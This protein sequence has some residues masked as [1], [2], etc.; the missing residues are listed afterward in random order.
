MYVVMIAKCVF[1][2]KM[3][4]FLSFFETLYNS[5]HSDG[6]VRDIKFCVKIY[7]ALL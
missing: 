3:G 5:V 6:K 1:I 2:L 4:C 7:A